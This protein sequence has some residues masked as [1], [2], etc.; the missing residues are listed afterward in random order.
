MLK[1]PGYDGLGAKTIIT[2]YAENSIFSG[3]AKELSELP[4]S[5]SHSPGGS[6]GWPYKARHK[7][8]RLTPI[9]TLVFPPVLLFF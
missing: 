4:T 9:A 6:W 1:A 5:L 8:P 2:L 7:R 3:N